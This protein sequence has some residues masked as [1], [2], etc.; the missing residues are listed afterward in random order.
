MILSSELHFLR[1]FPSLS[2]WVCASSITGGVRCSTPCQS[3]VQ[4]TGI[5]AI[6]KKVFISHSWVLLRWWIRSTCH[7]PNVSSKSCPATPLLFSPE[8]SVDLSKAD[9]SSKCRWATS[10]W[11]ALKAQLSLEKDE[12]LPQDWSIPW[13]PKVSSL[14]SCPVDL[15]HS[16][17][18]ANSWKKSSLHIDLSVLLVCV[19]WEL[20]WFW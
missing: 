4:F 12:I 16:V 2:R 13:C 9:Y 8:Q 5:Q 14:R 20:L 11:N 3:S 17:I 19:S 18:R 1:F 6:G 10:N 7:I 15:R